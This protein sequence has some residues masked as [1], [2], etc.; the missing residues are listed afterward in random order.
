ME[1]IQMGKYNNSK[2]ALNFLWEN[3]VFFFGTAVPHKIVYAL[4]LRLMTSTESYHTL[5]SLQGFM[6]F[7]FAC[8]PLIIL[9]IL[10][11]NINF[12]YIQ[13]RNLCYCQ[14]AKSSSCKPYVQVTEVREWTF[15]V[16]IKKKITLFELK[17]TATQKHPLK[18]PK[19]PSNKDVS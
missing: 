11:G 1:L 12:I 15:S 2:E 17:V 18:S 19:N 16:P 5:K 7:P 10:M 13:I 6:Y 14:Q 8:Y 9:L 3:K 4:T